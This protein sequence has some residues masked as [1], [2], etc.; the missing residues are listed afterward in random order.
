M[1]PEK[2]PNP[3]ASAGDAIKPYLTSDST[4]FAQDFYVEGR[5]AAMKGALVKDYE[6]M[7]FMLIGFSSSDPTSGR[8]ALHQFVVGPDDPDKLPNEV[9]TSP[10]TPVEYGGPGWEPRGERYYYDPHLPQ[11]INFQSWLLAGAPKA[12]ALGEWGTGGL[13]QDY[14]EWTWENPATRGPSPLSGYK[15]RR[16]NW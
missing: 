14:V 1:L 2:D 6:Q 7:M 9:M 11:R 3:S 16:H 10:G 12:N 13:P 5:L 4:H 15:K 8:K